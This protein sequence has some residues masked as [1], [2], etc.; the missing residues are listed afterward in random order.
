MRSLSLGF[1]EKVP[2]KSRVYGEWEIGT[3][4][5]AWRVTKNGTVLCGSQDPANNFQDLNAALNRIELGRFV[6][7]RQLTD[8]DI[9]VQFDNDL[10]VDVLAT[11]SDGDECFH[12]FCPEDIYVR[13]SVSG[14]WKIGKSNQPWEEA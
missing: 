3:Y 4:G 13:F 6:F 14:G 9:R 8:L 10:A 7:L 5:C 11:I 1:G 2:G 12:I